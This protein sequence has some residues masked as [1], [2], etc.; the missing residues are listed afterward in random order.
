MRGVSY[1]EICCLLRYLC[2]V[3]WWCFKIS[4]SS[5]I[6]N[7]VVVVACVILIH[8]FSRSR[9][10]WIW[11]FCCL[12]SC[13]YICSSSISLHRC[14][15]SNCCLPSTTFHNC[16]CRGPLILY[17]P[18]CKFQSLFS[19][20]IA[21]DIPNIEVDTKKQVARH[22]QP[23]VY[24]EVYIHTTNNTTRLLII[25]CNNIVF[26]ITTALY[27][28]SVYHVFHSYHAW[29]NTYLVPFMRVSLY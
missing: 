18:I 9:G 3:Y 23:N 13:V 25:S 26:T 19:F 2:Y 4:Y 27:A 22:N 20:W 5:C 1:F 7:T 17:Y 29:Y 28:G 10:Y 11:V 16:L 14:Y 8:G 15:S 12:F 6:V 24:F 21:C